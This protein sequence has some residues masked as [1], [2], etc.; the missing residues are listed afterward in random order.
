MTKYL[1]ISNNLGDSLKTI[2]HKIMEIINGEELDLALPFDQEKNYGDI[3]SFIIVISPNSQINQVVDL[4]NHIKI[5][6]KDFDLLII[7]QDQETNK[8]VNKVIEIIQK[9]SGKIFSQEN[10]ITKDK[11]PD[12]LLKEAE[13]FGFRVFKL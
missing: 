9:G 7:D 5:E 11:N 12:Q 6:G 8:A 10:L 2:P 4:L 3:D 13:E 1:V